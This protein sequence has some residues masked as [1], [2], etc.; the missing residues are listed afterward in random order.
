M[1]YHPEETFFLMT[2]LQ[3]AGQKKEAKARRSH[4]HTVFLGK[5]LEAAWW[6]FC[7]H[8]I[9]QNL[10]IQL[11]QNSKISFVFLENKAQLNN[12]LNENRENK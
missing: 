9:G 8:F 1:L 12:L 4:V 3:T 5:A 11:Y 7:L 2:T 6:Y 10:L